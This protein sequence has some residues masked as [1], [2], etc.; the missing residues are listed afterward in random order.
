MKGTAK[1]KF[2][3]I[4]SYYP[5]II[6]VFILICGI[7]F[8]WIFSKDGIPKG[9]NYFQIKA[10]NGVVLHVLKTD[11]SSISLKSIN[12]N[13]V[14]SKTIGINGGFFWE[15]QLLS[16]AAMDGM[17]ANGTPQEYGSGWF[18]AKYARGTMVYDRVTRMI[19]VQRA[20]SVD[21]LHITDTTK[22]WAQGGISMNLR[23]ESNWYR[24]A[25]IEEA[26]PF[27]DDERLRSGMAYD[28]DGK[29]YLIVSSTKCNAEEF[30][31]AIKRNIAVGNL[32]EAIF[33]DGDGSSQLLAG[34]V[35][36][37]G[38][39]RTVVQMIAVN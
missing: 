31:T 30:R 29:V 3:A 15:N 2:A 11:P 28:N 27:P 34:K 35:K 39:D 24:L 20:S 22:Y 32:I 12:D 25:A 26:M 10:N 7:L 19:D 1:E 4:R 17:P 5:I 14:R 9:V 23:D 8:G 21:D 33:L 6:C 36:L 18:N 37:K 16:I 13:V 38:D